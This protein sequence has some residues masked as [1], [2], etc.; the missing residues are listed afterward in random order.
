MLQDAA[1]QN[2]VQETCDE[3][4]NSEDDGSYDDLLLFEIPIPAGVAINGDLADGQ[5]EYVWYYESAYRNRDYDSDDYYATYLRIVDDE[6]GWQESYYP[7]E[8]STSNYNSFTVHYE[9]E[10]MDL[11]YYN[12]GLT[13]G[14]ADTVLSVYVDNIFP[15]YE[16]RLVVYFEMSSVVPLE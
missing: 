8:N 11:W 4:Y 3:N 7:N 1:H 2:Q 14:D 16:Y 15:D 12:M 10:T 9:F 5:N 13:G 6:M